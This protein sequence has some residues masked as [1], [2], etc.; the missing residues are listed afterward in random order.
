VSVPALG[1]FSVK[2]L[3]WQSHVG[4]SVGLCRMHRCGAVISRVYGS[5]SAKAVSEALLNEIAVKMLSGGSVL[6]MSGECGCGCRIGLLFSLS[7]CHAPGVPF[8]FV[9]FV[10]GVADMLRVELLQLSTLLIDTASPE[11]MEHRKE[12]I[13]FAWHHLKSDD[14]V[15]KNWAYIN[16]CRFIEVG[17]VAQAPRT[18]P[19]QGALVVWTS[20]LPPPPQPAAQQ[21][22]SAPCVSCGSRRTIP[23]PRSSCRCM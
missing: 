22:A 20:P 21:S 17:E 8:L 9:L 1:V 11:L 5:S 12:L 10:C 15:T 13:K 3:T 16:V 18:L 4:C 14:M 19:P 6:G 7:R 23:L 2:R